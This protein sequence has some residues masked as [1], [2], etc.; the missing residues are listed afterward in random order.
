MRIALERIGVDGDRLPFTLAA[1]VVGLRARIG[2]DDGA[3]A[4]GIGGGI[5]ADASA[6][7]ARACAA[8]R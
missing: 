3:V 5:F 1:Q 8:T 6:P 4:V 7:S 2:Q